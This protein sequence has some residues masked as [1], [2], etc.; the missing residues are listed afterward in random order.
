MSKSELFAK[1]CK[2]PWPAIE[3]ADKRFVDTVFAID[4]TSHEQFTLWQQFAK[5]ADERYSL[6]SPAQIETWRDRRTRP[7]RTLDAERRIRRICRVDWEEDNMGFFMTI[8]H[9]DNRPVCVSFSFAKINGKRVV[10]Y[11]GTSQL[12]DH[13]MIETW[14][15]DNFYPL[16][17]G[18]TRHAHCNA[19]NFHHC[20]DCVEGRR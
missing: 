4:A 15:E 9:L 19:E 7:L 10:F 20:L 12:V 14:F 1:V 2:Q 17:D 8:G 18:G 6:Y 11:E 3:R 13:A 5:Q 16:Y